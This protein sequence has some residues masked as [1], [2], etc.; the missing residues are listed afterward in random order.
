LE[1]L[2]FLSVEEVI[3]LH[4]ASTEAFGGGTGLRDFG[5]LESAVLAP[6]QTFDG[7]FL[8]PTIYEMAAALWHGIVC[9]H[10]FIDG[11]KRTGAAAADVFLLVNGIEMTFTANDVFTLTVD[12]ATSTLG[13]RDL[14]DQ[15]ARN[16]RLIGPLR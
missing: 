2:V 5:L 1:E 10:P 6:Q 13:R 11:N 4:E 8:Y 9:N 15:I 12:V 7:E 3:E 14:A 16:S